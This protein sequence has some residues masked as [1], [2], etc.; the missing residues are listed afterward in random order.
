[1][2]QK[3]R[4][5]IRTESRISATAKNHVIEEIVAKRISAKDFF[6]QNSVSIH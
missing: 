5:V 3:L 4:D 6:L 2:T 1:M